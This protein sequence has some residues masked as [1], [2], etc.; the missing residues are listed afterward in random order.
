MMTK[1]ENTIKVLKEIEQ[2]ERDKSFR[3]DF[4]GGEKITAILYAI[5]ILNRIKECRGVV[6]EEKKIDIRIE[7]P[8][9]DCRYW[10]VLVDKMVIALCPS[11]GTALMYFE[12]GM[13]YNELRQEVAQRVVAFGEK[14]ERI[15]HN[16]KVG[17]TLQK[18]YLFKGRKSIGHDE[19]MY[20]AEV[21]DLTQALRK[22]LEG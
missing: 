2:E 13:K 5:S 21:K 3:S 10:K 11:K 7:P 20:N 4:D 6:P 15:I 22:E 12:I 1:L 8:A 17:D 9:K 19:E 18:H 14:I 16:S